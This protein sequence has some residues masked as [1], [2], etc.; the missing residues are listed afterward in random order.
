MTQLIYKI[1][2]HATWIGAQAADIYHGSALDL[3]DGFIHLSAADQVRETAAKW[4]T[5]RTGLVLAHIKVDSLGDNLKWEA[6][7][8]GALF[9]HLYGPLYMSALHDV[10]DLPVDENGL[11]M[12]G[13]TIP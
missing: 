6:S 9:P 12:F 2:E 4:F 13:P 11:H 3:A 10:E 1:E 5:G 7:R 8:G